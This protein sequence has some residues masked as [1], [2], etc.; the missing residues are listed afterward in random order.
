M[1]I[2]SFQDLVTLN[3]NHSCSIQCSY[4][5]K[6]YHSCYNMLK[7][8]YFID[9]RDLCCFKIDFFAS[10]L[11][12]N[13]RGLALAATLAKTNKMMIQIEGDLTTML[14]EI[15]KRNSRY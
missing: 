6:V 3:N 8:L 10:Y 12:R 13:S 4:F 2:F 7:F 5:I 14:T 1:S 9:S 15:L 11:T